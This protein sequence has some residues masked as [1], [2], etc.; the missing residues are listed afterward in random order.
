MKTGRKRKR[1]TKRTSVEK[2]KKRLKKNIWFLD[3]GERFKE[4]GKEEWFP[5]EEINLQN[6]F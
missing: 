2:G 6:P 3:D 4:E 5:G 1:R